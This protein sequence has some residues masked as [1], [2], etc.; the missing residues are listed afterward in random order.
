MTDAKKSKYTIFWI[1]LLVLLL[2]LGTLVMFRD[3]LTGSERVSQD[4]EPPSTEWTTAPEG[5]V[6]VDLPDTPMRF[7]D[8]DEEAPTEDPPVDTE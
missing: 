4:P 5:G 6:E 8:P 7:E 3:V 2:V 1:I